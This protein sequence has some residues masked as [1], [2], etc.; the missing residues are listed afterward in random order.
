MSITT[1]KAVDP[2]EQ[3]QPTAGEYAALARAEL[4]TF[5][6]LLEGLDAADW[7]RPTPCTL[8]DVHDV[9]AHQAGHVQSGRGLVGILAQANP[10]ALRAYRRR[11]MST[12]DGMNQKQVDMRRHRAPAELIS[13]IR[14]GT[15]AAIDARSKLNPLSARMRLP[16][17]PVGMM[18]LRE[19]LQRIFSRDM[20][21]HRLDIVDAT[22]RPFDLAGEHNSLML[23]LTVEDTARFLQKRHPE[24]NVTLHLSGPGGGD[25]RLAAGGGSPVALSM[26]VN[27][28]V[29]RTG[30]RATPD[31]TAV[32]TSSDAS[33]AEVLALLE[34]LQAPY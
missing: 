9:A 31:Q 30:G 5:V 8:W 21:I 13:E 26:P 18:P 20:W 25:W 11:G 27:D 7:S 22:G 16:V 34:V 23:S 19:L 3:R 15:A 33:P 2:V 10:I 6:S 28:F 4:A 17:D 32:R 29:R 1:S 14:E 12:L 24:A